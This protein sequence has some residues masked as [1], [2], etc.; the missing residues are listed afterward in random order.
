MMTET[1]KK[2]APRLFIEH[3]YTQPAYDAP[4]T[5]RLADAERSTRIGKTLAISDFL[6][7]YDVVPEFRYTTMFSRTAEILENYRSVNDNC[8]GI[9]NIEDPV[10]IGAA[11]GCSLGIMRYK[12]SALSIRYSAKKEISSN[13]SISVSRAFSYLILFASYFCAISASRFLKSEPMPSRLFV[14]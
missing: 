13:L 9:I 1:V 6:R 7:A 12:S 14:E 10:Q 2:Y 11:L 8:L 3:A 5:E 4:Y